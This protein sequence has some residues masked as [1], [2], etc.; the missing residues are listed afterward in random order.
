VTRAR[1]HGDPP[2]D[3][4]QI[5]VDA[6]RQVGIPA[7]RRRLLRH[8]A[9]AVY[10]IEDAGVVARVG[11]GVGVLDRART[12]VIVAR[13]LVDQDFPATEPADLSTEDG[14]PVVTPVDGV[15][16]TFWR[17]YPQPHDAAEHD[18]RALGELAQ[19]LHNIDSLPPTRLRRF[20]PLRSVAQATQDALTAGALDPTG[21]RWLTHRIDDLREQYTTLDFPLGVGLIHGDLYVGNLLRR[22]GSHPVVLGDWDSVAIGP[23]EVDLVP[24]YTATRFGLGTAMVDRFADGYGYDL[25]DWRGYSTLRAIREISTLTALVRLAPTS[26]RS[27]DELA[28]RLQT[29]RQGNGHAIWNRQ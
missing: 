8:F 15:A 27:A 4:D 3:L 26:S 14:S 21:L 2:E 20:E 24:T 11:Y 6:C 12:A 17:Y 23:R 18:L 29:L 5:V 10:L 1:S 28:Y 22:Q 9:N 25:R 16:V 13:W 7:R 19:G